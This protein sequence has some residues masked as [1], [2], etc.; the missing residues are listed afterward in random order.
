MSPPSCTLR[1]L[2]LAACSIA[3]TLSFVPLPR[4]SSTT[5]HTLAS[6]STSRTVLFLSR[7]A[8]TVEELTRE[9]TGRRTRSDP[10]SPDE[11]YDEE[12]DDD[13]TP[14]L[15]YLQDSLTSREMD[16]P[17]H[18][19]LLGTTFEKPKVTVPYVSNS[20]EYV[21]SMPHGEAKELSQ[22]AHDEGL[23]CLGTWTREECLTL[24]R[25]L[26]VRDIVCRVVPY[27]EGGQR[28]WQA[29]DSSSNSNEFSNVGRGGSDEQQRRP[30]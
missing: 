7:T 25:Q 15:E 12:D 16:D 23:S 29:K 6:S 2:L 3:L 26:Q 8:T 21:L 19:L 18:I 22:F 28:G 17:F 27:T 5:T 9:R 30:F 20:L 14:P 24:G 11:E 1:W 10:Y 4:H 13:T